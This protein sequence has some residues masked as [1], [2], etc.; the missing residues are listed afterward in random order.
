MDSGSPCLVR[1]VCY[2]FSLQFVEAKIDTSFFVYQR[3]SDTDYLLLYVYDIVLT[4]SSYGLHWQIILA[5][6]QEFSMKDLCELHYFLGLSFF[7][8]GESTCWIFWTEQGW[9]SANH[10]PLR[11]TLI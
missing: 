3:G 10:A 7:S 1:L 5:L 4:P 8:L 6:W 9:Q 11:L 2:I